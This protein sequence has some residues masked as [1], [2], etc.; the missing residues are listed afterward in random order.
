MDRNRLAT[1]ERYVGKTFQMGF[2]EVQVLFL[3]GG[4]SGP[5]YFL[6]KWV[7]SDHVYC[8]EPYDVIPFFDDNLNPIRDIDLDSVNL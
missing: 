6:C 1:L 4:E 2:C 3:L 5:P 8:A 7:W